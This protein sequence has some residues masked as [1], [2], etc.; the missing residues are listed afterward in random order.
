MVVYFSANNV[1]DKK[2]TQRKAKSITIPKNFFLNNRCDCKRTE[3][4]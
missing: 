1:T 4:F 3:V 2:N